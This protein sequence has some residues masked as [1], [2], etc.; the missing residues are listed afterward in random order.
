MCLSVWLKVC[1]LTTSEQYPWSP[2][3]DIECHG[4]KITGVM[5]HQVNLKQVEEQPG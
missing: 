2:E 5:S 3:E 1:L 4:I